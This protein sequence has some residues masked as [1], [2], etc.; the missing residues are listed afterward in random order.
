MNCEE[1]AIEEKAYQ[2]CGRFP[3]TGERVPFRGDAHAGLMACPHLD[4]RGQCD[5]Y[6]SRPAGCR[7]FLC[8]SILR[9][10]RGFWIGSGGF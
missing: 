2:C 1:C 7:R 8:D 6:D 10:D 9:A 4:P 5:I 3:D